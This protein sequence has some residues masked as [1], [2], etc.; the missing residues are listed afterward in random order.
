MGC[1]C[2]QGPNGVG[3]EWGGMGS[4]WNRRGLAHWLACEKWRVRF[5]TTNRMEGV[6]AC[7]TRGSGVASSLNSR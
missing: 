5:S 4:E 3:S 7:S 2:G 1:Q 6:L